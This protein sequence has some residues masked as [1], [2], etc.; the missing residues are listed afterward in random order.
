LV[1]QQVDLHSNLSLSKMFLKNHEISLRTFYIWRSNRSRLLLNNVCVSF[2]SVK[3]KKKIVF[4]SYML[5]NQ[6]LYSKNKSSSSY[7]YIYSKYRVRL[8][9][10]NKCTHAHRYNYYNNNGNSNNNIRVYCLCG[11]WANA[12]AD[13]GAVTVGCDGGGRGVDGLSRTVTGP[14]RQRWT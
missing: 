2:C 7:I 8:C 12:R 14:H 1:L 5:I 3:K 6:F 9:T 13:F 10:R 11:C 4:I